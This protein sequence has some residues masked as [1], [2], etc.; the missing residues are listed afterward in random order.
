MFLLFIGVVT[1]L[2]THCTGH[3]MTSSFMGSGNQYMQLAKVLF[4]K[5]QTNSRQLPAFPLEVG[6]WS[7]RSDVKFMGLIVKIFFFTLKINNTS[8]ILYIFNGTSSNNR[9][10]ISLS[11]TVCVCYSAKRNNS[12]HFEKYLDHIVHTHLICWRSVILWCLLSFTISF[13]TQFSVCQ[14]KRNFQVQI[15][16]R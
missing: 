16:V 1:L 5:L 3:I 9:F 14:K 10:V 11:L 8:S 4:C 2:S 13:D 7:L 12:L 6:P 15:P